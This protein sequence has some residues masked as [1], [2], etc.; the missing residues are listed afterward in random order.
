[1]KNHSPNFLQ[2][3]QTKWQ[4]TN[5]WQVA[6]VLTA[7]SL[8][9]STVVLIRPWFFQWLALDA[10]TPWLLRAIAYVIFIVPTYQVLLLIY[11]SLLGQYQFFVRKTLKII[12]AI[13]FTQ[14]KQ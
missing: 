3:L 7:F 14:N 10:Q 5:A 11:G 9:G 12:H 2:K 4:L 1:M 8:T 13:T 6:A